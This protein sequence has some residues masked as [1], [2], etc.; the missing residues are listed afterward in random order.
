MIDKI[1]QDLIFALKQKDELRV[2]VLRLIKSAIHNE[3]IAKKESLNQE[4]IFRVLKSQVKS[5]KEAIDQYK[6]AGE[7]ERAQKEEKELEI[8]QEY[9]PETMPEDQIEMIVK[10]TAAK[11]GL[12][13]KK[14]FGQVM[15][16]VML[17]I[18]AQAEGKLVAEIVSKYLQ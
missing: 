5:R 11:L 4:D 13:E 9:M 18:G 7:A 1:N 17:K 8:I 14:N 16:E 10:E 3:E 2:G 12:S 6:K 15:K